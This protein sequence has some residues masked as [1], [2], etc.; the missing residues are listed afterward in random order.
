MVGVCFFL[1]KNLGEK[2]FPFS[3]EGRG[4]TLL[5]INK[6]WSRESRPP[7]RLFSLPMRRR[8]D[9]S[10]TVAMG[11]EMVSMVTGGSEGCRNGTVSVHRLHPRRSTLTF[12]AAHSWRPLWIRVQRRG[13][14]KVAKLTLPVLVNA[15]RYAYPPH[16]STL[17]EIKS[18]SVFTKRSCGKMSYR[19]VYFVR[20]V[21]FY[22][23]KLFSIR[24]VTSYEGRIFYR[25]GTKD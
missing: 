19:M 24:I 12:A 11:Q 7:W 21:Y 13:T 20:F 10:V 4:R 6:V 2:I 15:S 22:T 8:L 23:W 1:E 3:Y 17:R 16:P 5:T 14:R 25:M 9:L 18:S